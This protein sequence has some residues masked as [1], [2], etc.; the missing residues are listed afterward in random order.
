[1]RA[2]AL[3]ALAGHIESQRRLGTD[4]RRLENRVLAYAESA[5]SD[6]EDVVVREAIRLLG[7]IGGARTIEML[8]P[9]Y[10]M[11]SAAFRVEVAAALLSAG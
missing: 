3:W 4:R 1:M 6:T 8:E 9:L 7:A 5:L 2:Q 10:V 11:E